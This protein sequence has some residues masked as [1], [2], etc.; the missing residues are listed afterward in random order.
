MR[1]DVTCSVRLTW[2]TCIT[3]TIAPFVSDVSDFLKV[4]TGPKDRYIQQEQ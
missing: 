4:R 1:A 3:D 2:Q